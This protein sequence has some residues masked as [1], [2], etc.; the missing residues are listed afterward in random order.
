MYGIAS[1]AG[2]LL[3]GAFTD[4]V[5]WRWCFYI[6]LPLGAIVISGIVIF[7]QSPYRKQSA[8][9]SWRDRVLEL[10]PYGTAVFIPGIICVLL[11]LQWGGSKYDW[12]N[13]RIIVLFVLFGILISAFIAIQIWK[14]DNSTIP[15]RIFKQRSIYSA[16]IFIFFLGGAFFILVYFLPIWFQ[17]IKSVTATESGIRSLPLILS[18]VLF[19]LLTGGAITAFGYYTP[20]FYLSAIFASVGAGLLTTFQPDTGL[21]KW[22]GYQAI[23]GI[24]MGMGLQQSLIVAQTVLPLE[25]I[26]VGTATMIFS[27]TLGG[28]LFIS[29]AQNVFTNRLISHLEASASNIDPATVLSVGA[30]SLKTVFPSSLL[31]EVQSAYNKALTETWYTSVALA[32]VSIIGA[33][34]IEWRSVKENKSQG[35]GGI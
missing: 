30:T 9:T 27:Q 11:A 19:S 17:A 4:H 21:S 13:P 29:V 15:P 20:A 8:A 33:I 1:V 5:S 22:F 34:G 6:N 7:F 25:D 26:A 14:Q 12:K 18:L 23:F 35:V 28:A 2:P 32:A 31:D 3:G 10:D 16:S 24:G